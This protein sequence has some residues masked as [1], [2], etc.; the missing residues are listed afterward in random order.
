MFR[1]NSRIRP[2]EFFGIK[3]NLFGN[4]E[5]EDFE[6]AEVGPLI[7]TR[8]EVQAEAKPSQQVFFKGRLTENDLKNV[9]FLWLG[10]KLA[11]NPSAATKEE[12]QTY[13]ILVAKEDNTLRKLVTE[14]EFLKLPLTTN[15]IENKAVHSTRDNQKSLRLP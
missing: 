10:D 6:L 11:G 15:K 4:E 13:Y 2:F 7:R 5:R 12:Q 1:K 3:L 9:R 14:E 8:N